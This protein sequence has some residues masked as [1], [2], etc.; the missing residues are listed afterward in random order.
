M[1]TGNCEVLFSEL[2]GGVGQAQ[3]PSSPSNHDSFI[4]DMTSLFQKQIDE[5]LV[6]AMKKFQKDLDDEK[7]RNEE[8]AKKVSKGP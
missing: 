4:A 5:L 7:S 8:N 3:N 6:N 2:E 1:C